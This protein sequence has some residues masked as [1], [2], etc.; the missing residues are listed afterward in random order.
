M[1]EGCF[2]QC[3]R[4]CTFPLTNVN[5]NSG[6]VIGFRQFQ[7]Q[8]TGAVFCHFGS[9]ICVD[10]C[11]LFVVA[12]GCFTISGYAVVTHTC[13]IA[14]ISLPG[15]IDHVVHALRLCKV[16]CEG[17]IFPVCARLPECGVVAVQYMF[18]IEVGCFIPVY[19]SCGAAVRTNGNQF[20][21][22]AVFCRQGRT[23]D[24]LGL[25]CT[26]CQFGARADTSLIVCFYAEFVSNTVCEVAY[27]E[28]VVIA[29]IRGNPLICA[30][31]TIVNQIA[32]GIF[33]FCPA[34]TQSGI[35]GSYLQSSRSDRS[36]VGEWCC[37]YHSGSGAFPF[38][39]GAYHNEIIFFQVFQTA[40]G[41]AVVSGGLNLCHAVLGCAIVNFIACYV[42]HGIPGKGNTL[43]ACSCS[44]IL[45]FC[46]FCFRRFCQCAFYKGNLFDDS[47]FIIFC[48]GNLNGDFLHDFSGTQIYHQYVF[49]VTSR[50]GCNS[51]FAVRNG[52]CYDF[53]VFFHFQNQI[54]VFDTTICRSSNLYFAHGN[55]FVKGDGDFQ[56]CF[57][58]NFAGIF[59]A[60][61][62]GFCFCKQVSN[63]F[64]IGN[65]YF[66]QVCFVNVDVLHN[67]T[68]YH[69]AILCNGF[70]GTLYH[71]AAVYIGNIHDV[72]SAVFIQV[73]SIVI[74]A[75]S[76]FYQLLVFLIYAAVAIHI[77]KCECAFFGT[78]GN[79]FC[80]FFQ[81]K[82]I[83]C[84]S[85]VAVTCHCNAVY[86]VRSAGGQIGSNDVDGCYQ[87]IIAAFIA[88]FI[89]ISNGNGRGHFFSC[90][91]IGN[92]HLNILFFHGFFCQRIIH[93]D[94]NGNGAGAVH[95]C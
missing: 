8:I 6:N 61:C 32:H 1:V 30:F 31:F 29:Y 83:I 10:G 81:R 51:Q 41:D 27:S 50:T 45:G 53:A 80:V 9:D 78:D 43:C 4:F 46:C 48:F 88:G 34:E 12:I 15:N 28:G 71:H 60:E 73:I 37:G 57:G 33:G 14:Q 63:V 24:G 64:V 49:T 90:I 55:A 25:G 7:H 52:F 22:D 21:G 62:N 59:F 58:R 85:A 11:N 69:S 68:G 23:V 86:A 40:N 38:A 79:D 5:S 56:R 94:T 17:L 54:E 16:K 84:I 75:K 70:A 74:S 26:F 65:F 35:H 89:Q 36:A 87:I 67:G 92:R 20:I 82:F 13:G 19:I 72:H 66:R 95:S 93:V 42:C 44:N 18:D 77:P 91:S 2:R 39:A 3:N 76:C 47:S